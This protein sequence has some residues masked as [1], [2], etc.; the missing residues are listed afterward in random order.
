MVRCYLVCLTLCFPAA[1]VSSDE[2]WWPVQAV[3]HGLVRTGERHPSLAHQMMLQSVAGLAAKSVRLGT[4]DEMVW[5]STENVDLEAWYAGFLKANPK[6]E[7]RGTFDTWELVDRYVQRG[8]IKGYILYAPDKS[9][10]QIND[11]RPGMDLSV[12][13]ATSLAGLLDGILVS[14]RLEEEARAHGLPLLFDARAK[15]QAWCF[16]SYQER[17]NRQLLCA[18]DPKKANLRDLAIAQQALVLYGADEPTEAALKWLE[19]LSPIAGWNGGDEFETTRLSTIYGQIQTATDWCMNLPV[20]MAGTEQ[21]TTSRPKE[22]DPASIDWLDRRSCVS[23]VLT[24]GDNV[25]WLQINFFHGEPGYWNNPARGTIPFG[26]SGCFAHLSQLCPFA[27][28]HALATRKANDQFVEWGAGY[29][30][31]DLFGRARPDGQELLSRHAQ[32]TW[33]FMQR[34]GTRIIGFNVAQPESPEALRA[35]SAIARETDDLTAML[36]FQYSPYEGGAG[37]TF[38][39]KDGRGIEVPV[40]TARYSIWEHSNHRARSGTPAKVAREII[41]SVSDKSPRHDWAIVHAWSYFR[42]A[43]GND[44]QAE[45]M[46]QERARAKGGERGYSPALWCAQRLPEHIRTVTPEEL[47]WRIRMEHDPMTTKQLLERPSSR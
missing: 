19:P 22:F 15:S 24:D 45:N 37:K 13:V 36:V 43:P 20:L 33:K 9:K 31:P 14:D 44:E 3:P 4:G 21:D 41:G 25:Q 6:V 10:G 42:H 1:A 35:Y 34:T 7:L 5:V 8:V 39:V 16:E 28:D 32:R 26:W 17:F 47:A 12:N 11:H 38:W 30:Y 27:I 46:S 40:I 2:R 29:Y 18:Q 23:F